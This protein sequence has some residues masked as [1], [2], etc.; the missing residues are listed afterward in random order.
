[1]SDVLLIEHEGSTVEAVERTLRTDGHV[2]W[3]TSSAYKGLEFLARCRVDAVITTLDLH[4]MI[5]FDLL[6]VLRSRLDDV[7][8]FVLAR[9]DVN[10]VL[11]AMQLGATDCIG[12]PISEEKLRHALDMALSGA[13]SGALPDARSDLPARPVIEMCTPQP[14]AAARWARAV[15]PIVDSR[16]DPRTIAGWSRCIA[17]SPGAIRNWCFTA[18]IGPRQS[19][20][21][22]RLL[23]AVVLSEGGRHKPENLLDVVDRRTLVSLLRL[24]GFDQ[25]HA[26]PTRFQDFL[27][28]QALVRDTE[29]LRQV[30]RA[31][32][33]RR[34]NLKLLSA[35]A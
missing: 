34:P 25:E 10:D 28:H 5:A 13:Q 27:H 35:S 32:L 12:K 15:V 1:M 9:G 24:G 21:F 22:G 6:R 7:P 29:A 26:F 16:E 20:V 30:E 18:G 23:R 2:V 33:D 31:L 14:H 3:T 4:D 17:A 19:L 8:V 11:S